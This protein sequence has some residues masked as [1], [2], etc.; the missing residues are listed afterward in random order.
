[1]FDEPAPLAPSTDHQPPG[2]VLTVGKDSAS[3]VTS[4]AGDGLEPC[5]VCEPSLETV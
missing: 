2:C 1:M 5:P 3:A 4:D